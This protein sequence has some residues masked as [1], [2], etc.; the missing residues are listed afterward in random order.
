MF[1][2]LKIA[3]MLTISALGISA[4]DASSTTPSHVIDLVTLV[5]PPQSAVETIPEERRIDLGRFGKGHADHEPEPERP[6]SLQLTALDRSAYIIGDRFVYE[7]LLTNNGRTTVAF[8][9]STQRTRFSTDMPGVVAALFSLVVDDP[10]LGRFT[11]GAKS[12]Y[13][14][15]AVTGSLVEIRPK[16]TLSIR[17]TGSWYFSASGGSAKPLFAGWSQQ[18]H[19][20][21]RVHL[22][23]RQVEY[24]PLSSATPVTITLQSQ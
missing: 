14:S 17:A 22:L 11:V 4:P 9:A 13:G 21:A 16:E 7:L 8:P 3:A 1:R 2:R 18:L 10:Q 19:L 20:K 12:L 5:E 15:A 23:S 24:P 6:F